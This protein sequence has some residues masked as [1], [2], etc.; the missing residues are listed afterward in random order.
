MPMKNF[1]FP[2]QNRRAGQGAFTIVET[3]VAISIL[4]IAL[5]GPLSIVAQSLRSS[6]FSRDQITAFY[7]AQEAVEHIRNQRDLAGLEG[8]DATEWLTYVRNDSETSESL[9]NE[10]GSDLIK[11]YMVRDAGTG[12]SITRCIVTCPKVKYD[13][14][15]GIYGAS[16]ATI[17]DDSIFTRE[18]VLAAAHG[19]ISASSGGPL[20]EL[21]ITVRVS[22]NTA[23][24]SNSVTIKEHITNWQL[25]LSE[26]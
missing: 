12:Y 9:I 18:I 7:L 13:P 8:L 10:Q 24:I 1:F 3:L 11:A 6:Y 16:S 4:A 22:W 20:K 2:K 17:L 14:S 19:D 25:E 5:T 21:V 26:N 15:S 23:A